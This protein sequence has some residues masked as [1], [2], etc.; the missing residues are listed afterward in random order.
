M[1]R[2][3]LH[4]AAQRAQHTTNQLFRSPDIGTLLATLT[5]V[6]R[7]TV[8]TGWPGV[9][10]GEIE[11]LSCCLCLRVAACHKVQAVCPWGKHGLWLA[12]SAEKQQRQ[13]G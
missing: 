4:E 11:H 6:W 12:R 7:Y 13:V 3:T 9:T 8:S 5:G 10:M 1:E 2:M